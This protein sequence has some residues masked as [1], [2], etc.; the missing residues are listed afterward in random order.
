L[1]GIWQQVKAE[2]KEELLKIIENL[3]STVLRADREKICLRQFANLEK[4]RDN[5]GEVRNDPIFDLK[6]CI[7]C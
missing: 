7:K 1:Q 6:M 3:H 4:G 2:R 5:C